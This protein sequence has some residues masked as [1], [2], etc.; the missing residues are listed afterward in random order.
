[1]DFTRLGILDLVGILTP[2][3]FLLGNIILISIIIG[4]YDKLLI[5]DPFL[6]IIAIFFI[7][8]LLGTV[9]RLVKPSGVDNF[10]SFYLKLKH[11]DDW[12]DDK[13]PYY[14]HLLKELYSKDDKCYDAMGDVSDFISEKSGLDKMEKNGVDL[15]KYSKEKEHTSFFNYCKVFLIEKSPRLSDEIY[16]AEALVRLLAGV[17]WVSLLTL[18]AFLVLLLLNIIN[19]VTLNYEAFC[20]IGLFFLLYLVIT[21]R[22]LER[23]RVIRFKEVLIVWD[24]F[25]L[26]NKENLT[27]MKNSW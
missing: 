24:S 22:I 12:V 17:F 21:W 8:Y 9:L 16:R 27:H 2:G 19:L 25:Y 20:L 13:F 26:M 4:K 7:S 6:N 11:K 18:F 1:M 10:A 15:K 3:A 14:Y 23:F 5:F